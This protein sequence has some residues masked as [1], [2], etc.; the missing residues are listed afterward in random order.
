MGDSP[1]D[2]SP[3]DMGRN[4]R[5]RFA[6]KTFRLT[7]TLAVFP[8]DAENR[9]GKT[10]RKKLQQMQHIMSAPATQGSHN[11]TDRQTATSIG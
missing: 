6:P 8:L 2:V 11:K 10:E 4:I 1:I 7:Q 5:R 9:R 3:R